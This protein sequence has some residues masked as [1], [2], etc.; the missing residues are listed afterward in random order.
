MV[1]RTNPHVGRIEAALATYVP[2]GARRRRR[3]R[4]ALLLGLGAIAFGVSG[5]TGYPIIAIVWGLVIGAS[6]IFGR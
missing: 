4:R 6:E 3:L 1:D 2:P 5:V